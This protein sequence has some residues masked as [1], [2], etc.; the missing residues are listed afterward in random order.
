MRLT[1][2][3][4]PGRHTT[5]A[6]SPDN[7]PGGKYGI[8][9]ATAPALNPD[10]SPYHFPYQTQQDYV[11]ERMAEVLYIGGQA[12]EHGYNLPIQAP[13]SVP[14]TFQQPDYAIAFFPGQGPTV[15]ASLTCNRGCTGLAGNY[16]PH[17]LVHTLRGSPSWHLLPP[18]W[19][20]LRVL[21][22]ESALKWLIQEGD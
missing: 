16:D 21:H 7:Y 12:D 8:H 10:G 20:V 17:Q 1:G 4:G 13:S 18:G 15:S 11:V 2:Q 14:R 22:P 3:Y 9:P 6:D 5:R 19:D